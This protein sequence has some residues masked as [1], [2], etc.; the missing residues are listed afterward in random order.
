MA[1]QEDNTV[2]D[3]LRGL[4]VPDEDETIRWHGVENSFL[5]LAEPIAKLLGHK[6]I[7]SDLDMSKGQLSRELSP[8]YDTGLRFLTGVYLINKS[9]NDRLASIAV[10]QGMGLQMPDWQKRKVT[11]EDELKAYKA[12]CADAGLAGVAIAEDAKRRARSTR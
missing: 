8:N 3:N 11:V 1:T 5:V 4:T 7:C 6:Q 9:Q 10:C 12:A 2:S